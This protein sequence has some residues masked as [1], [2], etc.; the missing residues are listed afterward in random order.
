MFVAGMATAGMAHQAGWL[1]TSTQWLT[2]DPGREAARR[3]QSVNNLKQ[4]GLALH[5]YHS[6]YR[7]FPPGGTFDDRGQPQHSWMTLLLPYLEEQEALYKR[8]DLSVPWDHP[9]NADAFRTRV[10]PYLRPGLPD[11]GEGYAPAQYAANAVALGGN[12]PRTIA[13]FSDG[14]GNTF[15]AGEVPANFKPWGDPTNWRNPA[16]GINRSPDGFGGPTPGGASFLFA[17][18]SVRFL[19]NTIDPKVF[20]ALSTP[21]AN[22]VVPSD[23]N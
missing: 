5:N 20:K 7:S 15:V 12:I 4:I 6:V 18:G 14:T 23:D 21:A 9:R 19:K 10:N 2:S 11:N 13:S 1:F 16:K 17:D 22:D 8:V 3:S